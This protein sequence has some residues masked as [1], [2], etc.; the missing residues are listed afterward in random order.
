MGYLK[1]L[2]WIVFLFFILSALVYMP[3]VASVVLLLCAALTL[4]FECFK[5]KVWG[6]LPEKVSRIVKPVLVLMLFILAATMV[7][8][9][10][11]I[12]S[13]DGAGT[14]DVNFVTELSTD[15]GD[16]GV[17]DVSSESVAGDSKSSEAG[18]SNIREIVSNMEIPSYSGSPYVVINNNNPYFLRSEL[19]ANSFENY[20]ALDSKGRCGV[21]YAC[22]GKETM[23]TEDRGAIG[24]VKPSGWHT[25]KYD[26]V[27]GKYLYNRCHLIGYQ[28]SAENANEKNLITGTRYMNVDGMLPFENMVADYIKET[29]HHVLY[30]VT[31]VFVSDNLVA[32]GVLMEARSVED[33]SIC[34]CV[35]C[36]NVQPGITINYA[37][38]DSSLVTTNADNKVE[39]TQ[40]QSKEQ[41]TQSANE[42][43]SS[44]TMVY[45]ASSG[46]GKKYHKNP[47]CSGM[48][49]P[50]SISLE[51][52]QKRGYGSCSKC[53]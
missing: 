8:G 43:S 24:S 15:A 2:N 33:D 46:K 34:F 41:V 9:G 26:I 27:S 35:Y 3:S 13:S 36:F 16:S 38:G 20:S 47:S 22:V 49:G 18:V 12:D 32:S 29:N 53:W 39:S 1:V 4:P 50:L 52:A 5:E 7:P 31:P 10:S 23:P 21:A 17:E 6:R 51:E 44:G 14:D 37:S 19:V 30:R 48:N 11:G 40:A 28:L 25:V 45:I 42:N